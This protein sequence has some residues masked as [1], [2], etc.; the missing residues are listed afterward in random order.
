M[1]FRH[2]KIFIAV[3][4]AGSMSAAARELYI[5]QPTVSQVIAEIENEY[6]TGCLSGFPGGSTSPGKDA[7]FWIMPGISPLY[8]RRWNGTCTM[9]PGTGPSGWAPPSPWAAVYCLRW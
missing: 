3:A 8:L 2:L 7:S 9:P 6:G 4:Q 1:T 5:A